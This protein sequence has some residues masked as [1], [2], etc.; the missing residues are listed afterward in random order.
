MRRQPISDLHSSVL[1]GNKKESFHHGVASLGALVVGVVLY[2]LASA[3]G[4][5]VFWKLPTVQAR[6]HKAKQHPP[7]RILDRACI[8]VIEGLGFSQN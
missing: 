8:G 1:Q 6:N 3:S 7:R 2:C 4:A 5:Q